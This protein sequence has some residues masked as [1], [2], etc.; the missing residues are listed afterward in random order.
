MT[1]L[2][3]TLVLVAAT[4][5]AWA[6]KSKSKPPADEVKVPLTADAWAYQPNK[7]EFI[8]HNNV[9]SM[10][11]LSGDAV[12]TLK[13]FKFS[14]GTI[15][16]DIDPPSPQFAGM[17]FRMTDTKESEYFYLRVARAGKPMAM[18]AAQYAPII[19]GVNLWDMLDHY[20][21]PATITKNQWNHVKLVVSGKQ[22]IVYVN[23]NRPTL[24]IPQLEGNTMEGTIAFSGQCVIS[25][26]VVKHGQVEGLP[27]TAGFDPTDR[28][29]RYIRTWLLSQPTPLP[30]GRELFKGDFPKAS[31]MM[32]HIEAERRGLVN[33]TRVFGA[34]ESRRFVWLTVKLKSEKEQRRKVDLG[35]S[36]EVWVFLNGQ[37]LY[38]D[39]NIYGSPVRKVPDG[40]ISIEN[41]HFELPLNTG[42]NELL[43]GV[44]NSFFG[45]G[46][47]AR[48]D[49]MEGITVDTSP[50]PQIKAEELD[51]YLGTYGSKDF[52][53]KLH[54]SK[55]ENILVVK[56]GTGNP[57]E[58]EFVERDKFRLAMEGV[59]LEFSPM[60][61]KM[62]LKQGGQVLNFVR[63]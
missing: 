46:L 33:L 41:G 21:G 19:Q 10:K 30:E 52:G 2:F 55:N 37:Y 18:D 58:L 54:L 20:Q 24:E 45:W 27:A 15:E 14:D 62:V 53:E 23:D 6:Q 49:N 51:K 38:S 60:E 17:Y 50:K 57:L 35:F 29:P 3:L 34:S 48:L 56:V 40:R 22:M 39:K 59:V 26:L 1:K 16:F 28:D 43:V 7:A 8:S 36:D 44:A 32:Q 12:V 4:L 61:N 11:L 47:I 13:D 9:P 25:N 5:P 31:V 63:E 42:D